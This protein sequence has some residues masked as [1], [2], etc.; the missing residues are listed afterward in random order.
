M[1]TYVI[2]LRGVMP[3]GKNKVLMAP[4]RTALEAEGFSTVRTYIQSGN[5]VATTSLNQPEL[6]HLV[7]DVIARTFGGD[8][9]VLARTANA[10]RAILANN[11]FPDAGARPLHVT[12]LAR[13]PDAQQ[14]STF[15]APGYAP[16]QVALIGDVVYVLPATSYSA[17][18]AN[19]ALI[20]RRFRMAA[21]TRVL[22]TVEKLVE[23]SSTVSFRDDPG[24]A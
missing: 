16:D 23:L 24:G 2:L 11:P 7:H 5:V 17:V 15:L 8:I 9:A 12:L 3:T 10:F 18:K 22:A 20:E 14:V 6:E 13:T 19:N 1:E 21:T 4:L